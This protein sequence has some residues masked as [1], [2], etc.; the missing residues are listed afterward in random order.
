MVADH[1]KG[2]CLHSAA[3]A[4][5][6]IAASCAGW[7]CYAASKVGKPD[8]GVVELGYALCG[9]LASWRKPFS[10]PEKAGPMSPDV[11]RQPSK[12]IAE[13]TQ[14]FDHIHCPHGVHASM[15]GHF[16]PDP[17]VGLATCSLVSFLMCTA[18]D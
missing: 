4:V 12:Q 17:D 2:L 11:K 16:S 6:Y 7:W 3:A 14:T 10:G 8:F 1:I 13:A 18:D 15:A 5:C 9:G